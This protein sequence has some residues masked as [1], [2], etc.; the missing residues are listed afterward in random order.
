M[1]YAFLRSNSISWTNCGGVC[2]D[3]AAMMTGSYVSWG[4]W[5]TSLDMRGFWGKKVENHYFNALSSGNT[6]YFG[7]VLLLFPQLN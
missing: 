4:H 2:K 3:G 1:N 5:N 7:V 6:L